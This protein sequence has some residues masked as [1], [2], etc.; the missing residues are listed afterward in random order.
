MSHY[1]GKHAISCTIR[2][3]VSEVSVSRRGSVLLLVFHFRL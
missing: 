1:G 2:T 3:V